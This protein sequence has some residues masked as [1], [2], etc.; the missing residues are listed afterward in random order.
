MAPLSRYILTT[1]ALFALSAVSAP[2]PQLAG[3]GAACNSVLSSTD[4]GVGYG[5]EDAEDNTANTV[6]QTKGS[7]P[8]RRRREV[9]VIAARQLD[10][11]SD[12]AGTLLSA[13][14][15]PGAGNIVKTDGDNVDGQLTTD[16]ATVGAQV[17]S[18]EETGL[19][20]AGSSV[21]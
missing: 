8:G 9:T 16:G 21:P 13:A 19:E 6:S 10:K 2:V 11:I 18:D 14:G 20:Q 4:N 3:E 7:T 17:G 15:A 12:G 1:L 5:T